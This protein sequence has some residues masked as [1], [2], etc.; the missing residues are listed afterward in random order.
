MKEELMKIAKSSLKNGAEHS[1]AIMLLYTGYEGASEDDKPRIIAEIAARGV[2]LSEC[3]AM[4]IT[5]GMMD[6]MASGGLPL[7]AVQ[8]ADEGSN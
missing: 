6:A 4:L 5:A 1:K 2:V 3:F 8:S 7:P